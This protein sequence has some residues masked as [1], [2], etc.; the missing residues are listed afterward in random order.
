LNIKVTSEKND[1]GS[2]TAKVVVPAAD[3]DKA[4]KHTYAE[5]SNRYNFQG[6][7]KGHVPR[8]V[9]DGMVGKQAVLADATN[10]ILNEVDPLLVEELDVVP[11]EQI[12]Y[13]E[14]V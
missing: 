10:D 4:V 11:L 13:G 5:I 14:D 1:D 2:I 3:V 8:P 12:Q 6:F 9:I 7:R